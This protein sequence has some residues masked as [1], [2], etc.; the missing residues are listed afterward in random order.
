MAREELIVGIG[1]DA[2]DLQ[3]EIQR[4]AREIEGRELIAQALADLRIRET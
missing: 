2:S 4:S 1:A 3:R